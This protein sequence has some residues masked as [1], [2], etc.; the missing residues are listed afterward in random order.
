[1]SCARF[2]GFFTVSFHCL[3]KNFTVFTVSCETV[4]TAAREFPGHWKSSVYRYKTVKTVETVDFQDLSN[5]VW[6]TAVGHLL[7]LRILRL[8]RLLCLTAP[9]PIPPLL[10]CAAEAVLAGLP[11]IPLHDPAQSLIGLR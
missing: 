10:L 3:T 11:A 7:G 4:K 8:S 9:S 1:V 6:G 2:T 5:E